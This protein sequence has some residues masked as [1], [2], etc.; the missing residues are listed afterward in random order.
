MN[1]SALV[2]AYYCQDFLRS[3][4]DNLSGY[5]LETIVICQDGS[6]EH[7]IAKQYHVKIITTPDI[8]NLY[9]AW[10]MGI[11]QAAHPFIV[12]ANS[13]DVFIGDGLH[14]MRQYLEDH[15][16]C[17]IVYGDCFL[18]ERNEIKL[19]K[20][21]EGCTP[22]ICRV[23]AMPMWRKSL[24]LFDESFIVAG[25]H[26]FWMRAKVNG[27][28]VDHI[29]YNVGV[30]RRRQE[31]IEHRNQAALQRERLEIVKRY[32]KISG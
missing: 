24:G 1:I 8:P 28:T 27:W 2:S 19:W 10:N 32:S 4:L 21:G 23:G 31:S 13:D 30:Y 9:A 7:E 29:E 17:G 3:R 20:R 25:D 14:V 6:G 22:T 11:R 26:D 15:P 16:E 5:G 12:S 18:H